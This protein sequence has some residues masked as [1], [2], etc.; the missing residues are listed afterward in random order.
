MLLTAQP[1]GVS[2]SIQW[3]LIPHVG[4]K[5]DD[6]GFCFLYPAKFH[7]GQVI[8]L[9]TEPPA[10]RSR[11][12]LIFGLIMLLLAVVVWREAGALPPSPYDPLGPGA[13]PMALSGLLG[14]LSILLIGRVF[15]RRHIG[16]SETSFVHGVDDARV[17]L[18]RYLLALGLCTA[19]ALYAAMLILTS[20]N[21]LLLTVPYIAALGIALSRRT[22]ADIATAIAVAVALG[23]GLDVLFTRI[24]LVT[25]P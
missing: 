22:P 24:L 1:A 14:I 15:A 11:P 2:L 16:R 18:A 25:L 10:R 21:F 3:I 5:V 20:A 4:K 13:F 8:T 19:T 12:D 7:P 23:I 17:P 9:E 6:Y